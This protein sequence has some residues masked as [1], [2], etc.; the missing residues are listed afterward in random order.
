V[1]LQKN[2]CVVLMKVSL[3][4]YF[5][6]LEKIEKKKGFGKFIC[7]IIYRRIIIM[8]RE[9]EDLKQTFSQIIT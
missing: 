3:R 9:K 2:E 1:V 4:V 6:N 8:R 7:K 5:K